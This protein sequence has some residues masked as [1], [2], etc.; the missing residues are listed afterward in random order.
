MDKSRLEQFLTTT[1]QDLFLC[2][3]R[4]ADIIPPV[5]FFATRVK[6]STEEDWIKLVRM[7]QY[8][9]QS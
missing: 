8:L 3:Q 4:R 5:A 7:M 1:V 9:L 6:A 2:K